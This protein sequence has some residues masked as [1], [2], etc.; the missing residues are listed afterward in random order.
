VS[1]NHQKSMSKIHDYL[2]LGGWAF[3]M[4]CL[5][6]FQA[7]AQTAPQTSE[8]QAKEVQAGPGL[9]IVQDTPVSP[10]IAAFAKN[11]GW[12]FLWDAHEYTVP[13]EIRISGDTETVITNFLDGARN[14]G[15]NLSGVIHRQIKTIQITE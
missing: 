13:V 8:A 9:T 4:G 6:S 12:S 15:V 3:C 2:T 5:L 14:A 10:Q 11:N 7:V 1:M